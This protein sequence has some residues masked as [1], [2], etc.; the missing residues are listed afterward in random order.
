MNIIIIV[1]HALIEFD[2]GEFTLAVRFSVT[3]SINDIFHLNHINFHKQFIIIFML[4]DFQGEMFFIIILFAL[5]TS[6]LHQIGKNG[7][8]SSQQTA[9][10]YVCE[11]EE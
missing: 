1:S 6:I 8:A 2:S 5:L 10:L 4:Y 11:C 9:Y 3:D 7:F